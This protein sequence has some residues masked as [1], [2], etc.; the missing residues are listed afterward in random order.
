M[1]ASIK[2]TKIEV[3]V[4][5]ISCIKLSTPRNCFRKYFRHDVCNSALF[6]QILMIIPSKNK[7]MIQNQES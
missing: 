6:K 4:H 1:F 7:I 3:T 5:S 2:V